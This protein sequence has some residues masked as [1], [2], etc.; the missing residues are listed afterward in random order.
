MVVADA[1]REFQAQIEL[2]RVESQHRDAEARRQMAE[3]AANLATLTEQFNRFKPASAAEVAGGQ[4][5]LSGVVD[6][7]LN[8]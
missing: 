4:E 7:R 1:H 5:Q 2:T 8:L 6:A 3:I